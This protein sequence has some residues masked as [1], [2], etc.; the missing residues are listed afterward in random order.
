MKTEKTFCKN[1]R[2]YFGRSMS[3]KVKFIEIGYDMDVSSN[4]LQSDY[5]YIDMCQHPICFE[6]KGS[7]T[8]IISGEVDRNMLR[9]KGQAQ[10]NADCDCEY[11]NGT[12]YYRFI[13][14][15]NGLVNGK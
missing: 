13:Q 11:F 7:T 3:E 1:C 15:I 6:D 4:I 9:V 2:Y 8:D 10:L 14:W 12:F 5:G